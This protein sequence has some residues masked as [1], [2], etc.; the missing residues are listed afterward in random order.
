VI[1]TETTESYSCSLAPTSGSYP[2]LLFRRQEQ[3]RQHEARI[4]E[5]VAEERVTDAE[6]GRDGI[7]YRVLPGEEVRGETTT[8]ET[9]SDLGAFADASF[10][11]NGVPV[12]TDRSGLYVDTEQRLLTPFDDLSVN[13]VELSIQHA[14][15]GALTSRVTRYLTL[16]WQDKRPE[17]R[18]RLVQTD[19]LVALGAD[20]EPVTATGRDGLRVMVALPET[21]LP[22]Q[23]AVVRVEARNE[24]TRPLA[25][26]LARVFAR[27]PWLSDLTFYLGNLPPGGQREFE[28]VVRVPDNAVPGPVY[29]VVGFWDI[30]GPL[31]QAAQPLSCTLASHPPASTGPPPAAATPE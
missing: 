28:R 27:H 20:F 26:L 9:A 6:T 29:A 23:Q 17:E 2:A 30:L 31:R 11:V 19:V 16:R 1:R 25:C 3:V 14:E 24:G 7:T 8:R 15:L 10:E 22:G 13:V 4:Y 21:L 12:R 18:L 5:A